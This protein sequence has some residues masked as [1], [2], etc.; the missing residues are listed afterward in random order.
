MLETSHHQALSNG[1]DAAH[2]ASKKDTHL[3]HVCIQHFC[4]F[5]EMLTAPPQ[6]ARPAKRVNPPWPAMADS[7]RQEAAR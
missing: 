1:Q 6:A 5:G 4:G 2:Q 7:I 3:T